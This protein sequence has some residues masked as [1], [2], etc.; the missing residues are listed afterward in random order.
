MYLAAAAVPLLL[1]IVYLYL[2]YYGICVA[3]YEMEKP[4][5]KAPEFIK[6]FFE[7]VRD[8]GGAYGTPAWFYLASA[9][10]LYFLAHTIF[11]PNANS[12]HRLYRDRLSKA[13]LFDPKWPEEISPTTN[14]HAGPA[15]SLP[16]LDDLKFSGIRCKYAPYLI[17]N[18]ALNIRGSKYANQRGRDADFFVFTS[19]YAGGRATDYVCTREIENEVKGLDI[20]TAMAISGAAASSNMGANTIKVLSPTLAILNIRLGFWLRNPRTFTAGLP[21]LG[22]LKRIVRQYSAVGYILSEMAGFL[23]ED[24]NQIYLTDGGPI[25]NLG[26][27]ELLRRR[28]RLIIAIDAEADPDMNFNS[29]VALQRHAFIDLGVLVHLNWSAIRDA[30]RAAGEQIA[31]TGGVARNKAP[32]GP[33]VALGTIDY[34]RDSTP[35]ILLY[36]KSSLT[37]DENDY[38]VDYKRRRPNFPHETTADQFFS[39]EQFEVYRALGFHATHGALR[40]GD[41][42]AMASGPVKWKGSALQNPLVKAARSLLFGP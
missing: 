42:I 34:P 4:G 26:I 25:E 22:W 36:V 14:G 24:S 17:I 33:H 31:E 16:P 6:S 23:D 21:R 35:G 19:K 12:L 15:R 5:C 29:F 38:I 9:L 40:G 28:C 2:S 13:F 3:S 27:Y 10:L 11:S 30:T 20:A 32:V 8:I 7:I 1:W 37:G 39:E 18:T 41:R